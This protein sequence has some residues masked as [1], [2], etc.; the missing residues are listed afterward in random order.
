MDLLRGT[1]QNNTFN[2]QPNLKKVK[3]LFPTR[4]EG[5][6]HRQTG[7]LSALFLGCRLPGTVVYGRVLTEK[8]KL[9][10]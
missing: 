6:L 8:V 10:I 9:L 4:M 7:E 5:D 2:L 1:T 3:T